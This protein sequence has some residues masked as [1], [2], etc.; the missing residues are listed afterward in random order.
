[1]QVSIRGSFYR[2][3]KQIRN[4]ALSKRLLEKLE[5]MQS[6]NNIHKISH[7]KKLRIYSTRYKVEMKVGRKV[8]WV[9]CAIR[10][11]N[12]ELLR[13]KPESYFKKKL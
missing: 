11:N 13:L 10:Q 5:E 2:D 8:Y 4:K 6:A 7:L 12:I 9:L 3:W 1:M